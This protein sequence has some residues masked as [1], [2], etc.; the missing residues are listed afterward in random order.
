MEFGG[1][2][3]AAENLARPLFVCGRA[4]YKTR[5]GS[6]PAFPLPKHAAAL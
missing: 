5:F 6:G 2:K 1:L 4:P 3:K